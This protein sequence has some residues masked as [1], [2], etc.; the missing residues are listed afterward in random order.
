MPFYKNKM[1]NSILQEFQFFCKN[2]QKGAFSIEY[3]P[4]KKYMKLF[5]IIR[6]PI[7]IKG[8]GN[9]RI[10]NGGLIKAIKGHGSA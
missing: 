9:F 1:Y 2:N 8:S 3:K 4:W 6:N 7:I 5:K 10:N